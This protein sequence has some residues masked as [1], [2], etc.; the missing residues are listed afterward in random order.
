MLREYTPKYAARI[1]PSRPHPLTV[2]FDVSY[3]ETYSNLGTPRGRWKVLVWQDVTCPDGYVNAS[4]YKEK[5]FKSKE[6]AWRWANR[7]AS[8]LSKQWGFPTLA[9]KRTPW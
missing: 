1:R 9:R 2:Y 3:S 5:F 6:R 4:G 7:K 8:K